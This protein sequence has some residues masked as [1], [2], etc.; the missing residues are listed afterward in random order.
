M[1]AAFVVRSWARKR[2]AETGQ[3]FP[4]ALSMI[5]LI[6]GL[7]VVHLFPDGMPVSFDYAQQ[8]ASTSPAA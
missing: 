1:I 2:Q 5:G 3:Q 6:V 7:P 4:V 8:G